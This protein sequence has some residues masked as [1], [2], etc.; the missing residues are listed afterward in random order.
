MNVYRA[1][2]SVTGNFFK[3]SKGKTIWE[4]PGHLKQA[5]AVKNYRSDYTLWRKQW[6]IKG[7][8]L[9]EVSLGS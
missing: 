2:S 7:Y 3:N 8:E 9:V 4:T 5:L 1:L 6:V